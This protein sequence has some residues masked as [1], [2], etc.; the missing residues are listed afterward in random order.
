MS[1]APILPGDAA[2]P[3]TDQS[4]R[5]PGSATAVLAIATDSVTF[6]GDRGTAEASTSE[7]GATPTLPA[8]AASAEAAVEPANTP[9]R[10]AVVAAAST[11]LAASDVALRPLTATLA[12]IRVSQATSL[13]ALADASARAKRA[14]EALAAAE[15]TFAKLPAYTERVERM[16]RAMAAV[17]LR[18]AQ[19]KA[20]ARAV[21]C[22]VDAHRAA[23]GSGG[24][25]AVGP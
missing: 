23:A 10:G 19:V 6:G 18:A 1:R 22:C 20:M 12:S 14:T 2:S 4:E 17:A 13:A 25:A 21:K 15:A 8:D 3:P 5:P 9:A 24:A 16:G 11:A 7:F